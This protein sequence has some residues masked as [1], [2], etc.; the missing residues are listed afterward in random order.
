MSIY[1]SLVL[2]V[3]NILLVKDNDFLRWL[4]S[5][6]KL[7]TLFLAFFVC[8]PIHSF[9]QDLKFSTS[10]ISNADWRSGGLICPKETTILNQKMDPKTGKGY[11]QFKLSNFISD[12]NH[13]AFA[14]QYSCSLRM[15]VNVPKGHK[16]VLHRGY[17]LLNLDLSHDT[18]VIPPASYTY[19]P[20][21]AELRIEQWFANQGVSS[22]IKT[23]LG[24]NKN[25]KGILF[26]NLKP[27]SGLSLCSETAS[28]DQKVAISAQILLSLKSGKPYDKENKASLS[29]VNMPEI[30]IDYSIVKC[31]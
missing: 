16:M 6:K 11:L 10:I 12:Q 29:K 4:S 13:I 15:Y 30:G 18:I 31:N 2:R 25:G 21:K 3:Q 14:R 23:T 26:E 24:S 20:I 7:N 27:L 5:S 28:Q 1:H 22:A 17:S 19:H 8:C 9:A